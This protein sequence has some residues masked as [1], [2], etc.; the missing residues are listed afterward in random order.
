MKKRER[1]FDSRYPLQHFRVLDKEPEP[2][3]RPAL[4]V[5]LSK[6]EGRLR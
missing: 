2:D 5:W 3:E 1:T 6:R 4:V